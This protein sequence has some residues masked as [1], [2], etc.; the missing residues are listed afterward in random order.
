MTNVFSHMTMWSGVDLLVNGV[1]VSSAGT[2]WPYLSYVKMLL[3]TSS[4][5]KEEQ[6][7]YLTNFRVD[8]PGN[9]DSTAATNVGR[10]DRK[11]RT[12]SSKLCVTHGVVPL[13]IASDPRML[14]PNSEVELRFHHA[15][16]TFRL[17][18][19]KEDVVYV[20]KVEHMELTVKRKILEPTLAQQI[21]QELMCGQPVVYYI[22]RLAALGPM[23]LAAGQKNFKTQLSLSRRCSTLLVFTTKNTVAEKYKHN[24]LKM[25][26]NRIKKVQATFDGV[27]FPSADLA[28]CDFTLDEPG[29][30]FDSL[31]AA[32]WYERLMSV[33]GI[34]CGLT[35]SHFLNGTTIFAINLDNT[36]LSR[37]T[38]GPT[39]VGPLS[40]DMEW[41]QPL[42]DGIYIYAVGLYRDTISIE[43]KLKLL[44]TSY[45]PQNFG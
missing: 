22:G 16:D 38:I 28:V 36:V 40:L 39:E 34:P 13:D 30:K 25:E 11:K 44:N 5:Y 15:P 41:D 14:P 43:P 33:A 4:A 37:N 20:V 2:N 42:T 18:A 17:H 29:P 35:Y 10:E 3:S 19:D 26:T 32:V 1:F 31:K 21:E 24:P 9:L 12:F 6:L 8:T 7:D 23:E 27:Q 45:A